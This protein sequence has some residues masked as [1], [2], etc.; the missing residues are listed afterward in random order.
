[1]QFIDWNN[2]GKL[3]LVDIGISV[4]MGEADDD[5]NNVPLPEVKRK[6]GVGCL[7]TS[8]AFIKC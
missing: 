7:T 2:N 3:Y 1:M 4:A 6:S 5:G 8:L